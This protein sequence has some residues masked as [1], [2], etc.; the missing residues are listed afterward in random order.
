[1][2]MQQMTGWTFKNITHLSL[3]VHN[4]QLQKYTLSIKELP[5]EVKDNGEVIKSSYQLVLTMS[6]IWPWKW[7]L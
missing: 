1:M 2:R 7:C 3:A 6:Q 5:L 4:F